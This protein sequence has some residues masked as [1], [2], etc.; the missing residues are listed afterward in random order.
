MWLILD[1]HE[2][3]P[4]EKKKLRKKTDLKYIELQKTKRSIILQN[5]KKQARIRL[6]HYSGK[7]KKGI[8][9]E[10]KVK[11][12]MDEIRKKDLVEK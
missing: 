9:Q 7:Q 8:K 4:L 10:K 5:E 3:L 6:Y 2:T 11:I 12:K 1:F